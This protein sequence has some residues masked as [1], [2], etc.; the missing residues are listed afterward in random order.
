MSNIDSL[1]N[2]LTSQTGHLLF[3]VVTPSLSLFAISTGWVTEKQRIC[4][5]A[6]AAKDLRAVLALK[7]KHTALL[8]EMRARDSV[9]ARHRAKGQ[10]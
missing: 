3:L 7:Q 4:R 5:T 1:S 6:L 8:H 2:T 10:R 9:A